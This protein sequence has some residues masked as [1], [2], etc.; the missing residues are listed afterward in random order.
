MSRDLF[1][2]SVVTRHAPKRSKWMIVGSIF[3]HLGV[4]AALVVIPLMSALN[5]FVVHAQDLVF[6]TVPVAVIP[7]SP[8]PPRT[9]EQPVLPND[10]NPNAAPP[11][12]PEK[13]VTNDVPPPL[14][15]GRAVAGVPGGTGGPGGTGT[16]TLLDGP[17]ALPTLIQ[18]QPAG[19]VRPGG[20]IKPP[21]RLAGIAPV[22]PT[23]AKQSR[24]EGNVILE[25]TI[26]E[27]GAVRDVRVLRSIPL[28]DRA[29]IDAVSQWRYTPT[30][31]N[32]VAVPVILTVT[33]V[34][35]LK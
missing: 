29:A 31:L 34:F 33:V 4:L 22:Y 32:G 17:P 9:T 6:L 8:P 19:P 20:D 28:L 5:H 23:L 7:E 18:R 16:S 14:I 15:G 10:I 26:D 25:A 35:Q 11:N 13:P 27:T 2:E 30:K 3:A 12:P 21:T 24:I 1:A